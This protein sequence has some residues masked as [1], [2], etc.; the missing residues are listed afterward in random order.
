MISD[1]KNVLIRAAVLCVTAI[2]L[3]FG[4]IA[5][6]DLVQ[7]EQYAEVRG[8]GTAEFMNAGIVVLEGERYKK[9]PAVT[10]IL[11]T[12]I[13]QEA[14]EQQ[15]IS[16]SRY[17][18]GGQAD[19]LILLSIDATNRQIHQLQIDRDTMTDVTV[20]SVF[21]RETGTRVMQICL[22]NSYGANRTENAQYTLSAVRRLMGDDVEIIG[23]YAVDYS[24]VSVL[25]DT[26]GGVTVTVPDDMTS[27]NPLW[28]KGKVIRLEGQEAETF[29]R[30][31]QTI[32]QGTNEERMRRQNEFMRSAISQMR[33]KL[34]EDSS[35]ASTLL[36]ALKQ[37]ATTS[38]SDQTLLGFLL[39]SSSYTVLPVEY[40]EGE[41]KIGD[42]GYMEFYADENAAKNWV[43]RHL[44]Y[45]D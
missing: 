36:N 4:G 7:Q 21:G 20:L 23:Y 33:D 30:T 38:L 15:G 29:V 27:V 24:A 41:Y 8:K 10:T 40:L 16:T 13:D 26:L 18:N 2:I 3:F 17:R 44:Y 5:V 25:N 32:G 34:S 43:F 39:D 6:V 11:V 19:F 35:F 1:K 45:K 14:N 9:T 22:A 31:R 28:E 37:N 12:G 42:S